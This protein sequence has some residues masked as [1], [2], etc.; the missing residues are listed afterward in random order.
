MTLD[1]VRKHFD[2]KVIAGSNVGL[3]CRLCA[4]VFITR[5]QAVSE[6]RIVRILMHMQSHDLVAGVSSAA[7]PAA[8][9]SK[10]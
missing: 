7:S 10:K 4:K 5:A 9:V 1:D 2:V 3:T 8:V 6:G